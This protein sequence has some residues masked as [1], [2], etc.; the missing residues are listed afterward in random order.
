MSP[1]APGAQPSHTATP[2]AQPSRG[3]SLVSHVSATHGPQ[4]SA[5]LERLVAPFGGWPA[6]VSPGETVAVKINLLRGAA[7]EAAVST[8]PETLR[9]VLHALR[10]A[11]AEPFVADSP[12]GINGPAK[13]ARAYRISGI[14]PMCAEEGVQI[15][16]VED[17]PV[18]LD[19]PEGVLYRSFRVGRPFL[20]ADAIVQVGV[21]KTHQLMR[22]T[23]AVKLTYGCIPGLTKAHLHVRA[24]RRDDFADMLLDL[25]RAVAPRFSIIDGIIAMEGQG[26]G[27]G[28]PREL[29]SLFAAY[30]AV[31]LDA[32]L[33]DRTAHERT[34]V[35]T[36]SAAARRGLVDLEDPYRLAGDPIVATTDFK[37]A[38]RDMQRL[39]PAPLHRMLRNLITARPRLVDKQACSRCGECE[40]ICGAGAI[41]LAPT[42]LFDDQLCVRCFCC[43]EVCPTA[44]IDAVSPWP[45][46]LTGRG[47]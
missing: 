35:Y 44:A 6:I 11:G 19:A 46:R 1:A 36:L 29:D 5:A 30:D 47:Q 13:V 31:A 14:G 22:L 23:G 12:G 18:Q 26:P 17:V 8:H 16:D 43:T 37:Q 28:K 10:A 15:V 38:G 27:N 7:P 39:L 45:M 24:Q 3:P 32:A 21:L 41:T 34:D 20:D 40:T 42:P 2:D 25:H 9:A 4:L 33:A